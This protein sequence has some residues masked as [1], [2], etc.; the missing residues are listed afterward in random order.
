MSNGNKRQK[1]NASKGR[2][3]VWLVAGFFVLGLALALLLFGNQISPGRQQEEASILEQ[4]PSARGVNRED[5]P[6]PES[7]API[8]VGDTAYN[9][10]LTDLDGTQVTL[11]EFEGKPVVVNFWATWCPPCR[12]EMPEFQQAFEDYQEDDL[13]ILAVNEAEQPETVRSFFYDQMGYT[14]TP[15]LDEEGEVAEAYGAVGLPS[16]FFIDA[17]GQVTAVHRGALTQGQLQNYL[18]ETIQ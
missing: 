10:S 3:P 16:T 18:A 17:S 8:N 13:V 7:G 12:L 9:F 2:N 11:A 1:E 5:V 15:L 14:Y 4:V 6:L